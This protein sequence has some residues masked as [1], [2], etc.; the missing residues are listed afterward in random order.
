MATAITG[1]GTTDSASAS[2]AAQ[3]SSKLGKDEFVKLLIAQMGNQ[4]PTSPMDSNA[5]VAQLAQFA[6]LEQLQSANGSLESLLVAQTSSSQTSAIALV[7]KT[8]VYRTDAVHLPATGAAPILAEIPTAAASATLVVLDANGKAVST[9]QLGAQAAGRLQTTWDGKDDK[10]MR[11][12]PGDYSL[13]LTAADASGKNIPV[14]SQA[15]ALI[16]G[17]SFKNGYAELLV[18]SDRI[19]L[20]DV[21]EVDQP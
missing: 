4:D 5:F 17:V 11:L 1:L 8:A 16:N 18:G 21:I 12:P 19:K 7:G 20:S 2:S 10:G 3:G 9:R 13:R 6:S 14:S 15:R